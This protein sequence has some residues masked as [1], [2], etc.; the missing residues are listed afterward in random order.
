LSGAAGTFDKN[1]PDIGDGYGSRCQQRDTRSPGSREVSSGEISEVVYLLT[2]ADQ[3]GGNGDGDK[4][5]RAERYEEHGLLKQYE[6][7]TQSRHPQDRIHSPAYGF[8]RLR[9]DR[10]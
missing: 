5:A 9:S 4:I 10:L 3:F 8:R 2:L 1:R 7:L 6:R